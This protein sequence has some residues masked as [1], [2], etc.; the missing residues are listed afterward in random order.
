MLCN[1]K[2]KTISSKRN[3]ILVSEH[4]G[5]FKTI[6]MLSTQLKKLNSRNKSISISTSQTEISVRGVDQFLCQ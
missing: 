6:K 5:E 1:S 2:V 3:T 4:S